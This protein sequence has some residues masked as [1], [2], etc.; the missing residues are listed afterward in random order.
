MSLW[1][2]CHSK[3]F[4]SR[5]FLRDDKGRKLSKSLGNSPDPITLFEKYGTDAT[6]FSIMLMSPQGSD[7]YFSE[8]GIEVGRNFYD[9]D[10]E[11]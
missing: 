1:V 8:N 7:V 9:Q 3:M 11:C 4:I 2:I 6:R 5:V 10:L